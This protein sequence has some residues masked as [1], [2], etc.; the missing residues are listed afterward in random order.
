MT[1]QCTGVK[2]HIL[3]L[4]TLL[5]AFSMGLCAAGMASQSAFAAD[6][7]YAVPATTA[8]IWVDVESADAADAAVTGDFA[9]APLDFQASASG[10]T[11]VL[12]ESVTDGPAALTLQAERKLDALVAVTF[13]DANGVILTEYASDS[14]IGTA[15][16]PV[17]PG[18][19]TTPTTATSPAVSSAKPANPAKASGALT[20]TG[21]AV[22]AV[23]VVA[24]I[25]AVAAGVIVM[26]FRRRAADK[27]GRIQR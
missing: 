27:K 25:I 12:D 20:S 14:T 11:A 22:V 4:L 18:K 2:P 26:V 3:R 24:V 15:A 10:V 5:L 19:Q 16:K 13:A 8:Q 9:G 17:E 1:R 7:S 23:A 6:A 21:S